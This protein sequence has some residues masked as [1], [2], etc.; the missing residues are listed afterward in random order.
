MLQRINIKNYALIENLDIEF[1][2]GLNVITGET[3]AGKS[4]IIDAITL[5][6]GQRGTRDNIR[7]GAKKMVVQGVFDVLGNDP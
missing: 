2:D 5:L 1:D 6:L 3:G 4:I 7:K